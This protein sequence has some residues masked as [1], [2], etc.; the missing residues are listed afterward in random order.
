[1]STARLVHDQ[2]DNPVVLF[3]SAWDAAY[4]AR[5]YRELTFSAVR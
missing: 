3:Q 5:E 4:M 2:D 1:M